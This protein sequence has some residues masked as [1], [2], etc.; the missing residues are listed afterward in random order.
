MTSYGVSTPWSYADEG[1]IP[2]DLEKR[3]MSKTHLADDMYYRK[4]SAEYRARWK[5]PAAAA[6]DQT[7]LN[8]SARNIIPSDEV[9]LDGKWKY[10]EDLYTKNGKTTLY[11]SDNTNFTL[12]EAGELPMRNKKEV[13]T[14]DFDTVDA[15]EAH[16]GQTLFVDG[17]WKLITASVP[18]DK[19]WLVAWQFDDGSTKEFDQSSGAWSVAMR[20]IEPTVKPEDVKHGKF[21]DWA[22]FDA[23]T[24]FM[25]DGEWRGLKRSRENSVDGSVE[26]EYADGST[27]VF[28]EEAVEEAEKRNIGAKEVYVEG[29]WKQVAEVKKDPDGTINEL[30]FADGTSKMYEPRDGAV[31]L[32]VRDM[33][34]LWMLAPDR[35]QQLLDQAP[36]VY[37]Y[38]QEVMSRDE[39]TAADSKAL[40]WFENYNMGLAE[41]D[42]FPREV[43]P[44]VVSV[45]HGPD[46]KPLY[47]SYR[48]HRFTI[49][50]VDEAQQKAEGKIPGLPEDKLVYKGMTYGDYYARQYTDKQAR[51]AFIK[52]QTLNRLAEDAKMRARA[53]EDIA[54]AKADIATAKA[55][56]EA[57]AAAEAQA[58]VD[59]AAEADRLAEKDKKPAAG[60]GGYERLRGA[61]AD[62]YA[63]LFAAALK[64]EEGVH[65]IPGKKYI[66]KGTTFE[67]EYEKVYQEKRAHRAKEKQDIINRYAE[68]ALLRKN[69]LDKLDARVRK[70]AAVEAQAKID[71]AVAEQAKTDA[72]AAVAE[73]AKIDTAAAEQAK[74]DTAAAEQA[75][76]DTAAAEQPSTARGWY[77]EAV[78]EYLREEENVDISFEDITQAAFPYLSFSKAGDPTLY[79]DPTVTAALGRDEH[80]RAVEQQNGVVHAVWQPT[81]MQEVHAMETGQPVPIPVH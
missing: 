36:G 77:E 67:E 44:P 64:E 2:A 41:L 23:G 8:R 46:G 24:Q 1:L 21:G 69:A 33:K 14:G 63:D 45:E 81:G 50:E 51:H 40:E 19:P 16:V 25:L 34:G 79:G 39:T 11:F 68:D 75:K 4:K 15:H 71:T 53:L 76:I 18:S 17:K 20:E 70:E 6:P 59:A 61:E 73:Q 47:V 35:V 27:Q 56:R 60:L 49:K 26:V 38:L 10:V 37:E 72:A 48:G 55:E 5:D 12:D 54:T 58:K 65:G 62:M 32:Q 30:V 57:K 29:L 42:D 22:S 3:D 66:Y 74:I 52:Q 28:T 43:L 78:E 80:V 7:F 31:H 9:F 13:P